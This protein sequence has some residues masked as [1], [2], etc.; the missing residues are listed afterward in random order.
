M[1]IT[2]II[3]VLLIGL[4]FA[5]TACASPTAT[6]TV[7]KSPTPTSTPTSSPAPITTTSNP[8]QIVELNYGE[9]KSVTYQ[10]IKDKIVT[11]VNRD[12]EFSKKDGYEYK[13]REI[14]I[15]NKNINVFMEL[16]FQPSSK[17]WLI[18]DAYSW[19]GLVA[20]SGLDIDGK[21]AGNIYSTGYDISVIMSTPLADGNVISWGTAKINNSG[22][23]FDNQT[24]T[25]EQ[26]WI[27]EAGVK[28][29]N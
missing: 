15:E 29:L 23:P 20:A 18:K 28:L 22:K 2:R 24:I 12:I 14:T 5:F 6:P 19:L 10:Q 9:H 16:H 21:L 11:M 25:R 27:D 8:A 13:L 4:L 26:E 17:A 3:T 1:R 7:P